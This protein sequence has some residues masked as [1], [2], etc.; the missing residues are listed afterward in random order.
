[1]SQR[2]TVD[3]LCPHRDDDFCVPGHFS[4]GDLSC[5]KLVDDQFSSMMTPCRDAHTCNTV[6]PKDQTS[7]PG[8]MRLSP[9]RSS[10]A[11]KRQ[12]SETPLLCV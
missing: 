2:L 6:M 4:E 12:V 1:M 8:V 10:A 11:V 7:L 3:L 5:Q 9:M